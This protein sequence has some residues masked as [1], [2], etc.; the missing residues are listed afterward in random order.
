MRP[1]ATRGVYVNFLGDEGRERVK[2]AYPGRTYQRLVE[3][4]RSYDP[5]N[6]FRFN[7]NIPPAQPP[8]APS[9]RRVT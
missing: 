9:P 1:F 7:Q 6:F 8:A 2:A 5:T 4:K 3:L